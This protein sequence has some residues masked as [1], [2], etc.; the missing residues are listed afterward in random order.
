MRLNAEA[1][2]WLLP[3]FALCSDPTTNDAV[4][5]VQP[6]PRGP[7]LVTFGPDR[8]MEFCRVR[9]LVDGVRQLLAA[10]PMA[11][12]LLPAMWGSGQSVSIRG[13][14]SSLTSW[15]RRACRLAPMQNNDLQMIVRAHECVMDGFERF[16]QGHLITLFRCGGFPACC[17][18]AYASKAQHHQG[19]A[20]ECPRSCRPATTPT[21]HP[22]THPPPQ[23]HQLL[24]HR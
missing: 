2:C 10:A 20:V 8:V 6:S 19:L 13:D 18:G 3:S 23:R 7:G 5:G 15:R 9:R 12:A 1:Q 4:E 14:S 16:A 17:C 21:T 22:L 11:T 24:W